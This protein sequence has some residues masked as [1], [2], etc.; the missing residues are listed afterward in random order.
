VSRAR[1][2][3]DHV[4]RSLEPHVLEDDDAEAEPRLHEPRT[5]KPERRTIAFATPR[6]VVEDPRDHDRRDPP[7]HHEEKTIKSPHQDAPGNGCSVRSMA[8]GQAEHHAT[9]RPSE[10]KKK[11]F[12]RAP[13]ELRVR[14]DALVLRR[15]DEGCS[16]S[17]SG[18]AEDSRPRP[19]GWHRPEQ[20]KE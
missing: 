5:G 11:V 4:E 10:H 17:V 8:I 14:E 9:R 13:T 7:R 15:P 19:S 2:D 3:D 1:Q 16:S 20:E 6:L 12:G 18:T